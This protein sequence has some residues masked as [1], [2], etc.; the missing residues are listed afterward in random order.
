MS[1]NIIESWDPSFKKL[2]EYCDSHFT[3]EFLAN[4]EINQS[5]NL[6]IEKSLKT[7]L[8]VFLKAHNPNQPNKEIFVENA[9]NHFLEFR[10]KNPEF[11]ASIKHFTYYE[12][13]VL[14]LLKPSTYLQE[15]KVQRNMKKDRTFNKHLHCLFNYHK[16]IMHLVLL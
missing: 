12:Q 10:E 16:V 9:V 8:L 3:K 11:Q 2:F 15:K 13:A 5:K 7:V 4:Y 6:A 1:T 14:K